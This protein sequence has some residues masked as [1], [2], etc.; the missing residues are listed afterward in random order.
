MNNSGWLPL[1]R[2]RLDKDFGEWRGLA[3]PQQELTNLDGFS[4]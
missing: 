2:A 3:V 1:S 4:R